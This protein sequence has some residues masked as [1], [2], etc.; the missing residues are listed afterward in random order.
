MKVLAVIGSPRKKG[1]TYLVV[2]QI[3]ERL[4]EYDTS[5]D[6]EYLFLRDCNLLMCTGCFACIA[7]GADKC[8]LK[9][10][11]AMIEAKMTQ[12][13]G[14]ILA[15][16]NYAM[17]VPAVM[18]NFIDRFAYTLHRPLFFDKAFLAVTTTGGVIGAKQA[19]AQLSILSA[20]GKSA[21]K[22]GVSVPPIPMAGFEKRAGKKIMKT[23]AAFYRGLKKPCRK[24][25][26]LSDWAY[27]HSFKSLTRFETYQ[28]VCPADYAYYKN[29]EEYFYPL[30]GHRIRRMIGKAVKALL[31]FGLKLLGSGG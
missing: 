21:K 23:S 5:I 15:A 18:K 9:D 12:A 28:N 16:P 8:P 17:A 24:L 19:L 4:M 25:P 26:G 22:L 31:R 1:N 6:F 3:R 13:D 30:K 20:G 10:D 29:K 2:E 11:R 27:F 14:I 7:R